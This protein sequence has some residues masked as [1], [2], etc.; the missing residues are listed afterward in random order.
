MR[1][2]TRRFSVLLNTI[3]DIA[4][5]EVV[6]ETEKHIIFSCSVAMGTVILLPIDQTLTLWIQL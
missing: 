6:K 1:V 5:E 2:P 4:A 3:G